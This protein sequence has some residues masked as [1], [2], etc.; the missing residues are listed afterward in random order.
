MI[1]SSLVL[2]S[3]AETQPNIYNKNME[4]T[5]LDRVQ[6]EKTREEII[7]IRADRERE[8]RKEEHAR[9]IDYASLYVKVSGVFFSFIAVILTVLA[10]GFL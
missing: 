10:K 3:R 2:E 7:T 9:A 6:I 1:E 5:E 4:L 8:D